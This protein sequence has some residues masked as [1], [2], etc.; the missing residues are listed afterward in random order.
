MTLHSSMKNH[1]PRPHHAAKTRRPASPAA[2]TP[3]ARRVA[4]SVVTRR[5]H[6]VVSDGA[7]R[8]VEVIDVLL[9]R[10]V[11]PAGRG[12]AAGEGLRS[13]L[14]VRWGARAS[15]RRHPQPHP[16]RRLR[17]STWATG[18]ASTAYAR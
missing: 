15:R 10:A 5:D 18:P 17:R 14:T 2:N 16:R 3:S 13:I 7:L 11:P 6:S 4:W 1:T 12:Y 8:S 9:S